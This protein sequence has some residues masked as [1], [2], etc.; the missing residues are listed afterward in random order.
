MAGRP[1]AYISDVP[2]RAP[3]FPIG[4]P[5]RFQAGF[6]ILHSFCI[7]RNIQRIKDKTGSHN[8][9]AYFRSMTALTFDDRMIAR[10]HRIALRLGQL[11]RLIS[12]KLDI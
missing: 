2:L 9:S 4:D 5:G 6:A 7:Y 3:L 8:D 1:A 10:S 12:P 11:P